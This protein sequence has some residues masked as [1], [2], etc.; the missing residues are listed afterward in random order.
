ML[1][2]RGSKNFRNSDESK[3]VN[4]VTGKVEMRN[5]IPG[6]QNQKTIKSARDDALGNPKRESLPQITEKQSNITS[7]YRDSK[8]QSVPR[9]K[10]TPGENKTGT[11]NDRILSETTFDSQIYMSN[12]EK[13]HLQALNNRNLQSNMS[14]KNTQAS[15]KDQN[16]QSKLSNIQNNIDFASQ[17]NDQAESISK[18]QQI[19]LSN[20]LVKEDHNKT[21]TQTRKDNTS[22]NGLKDIPEDQDKKVYTESINPFQT[23]KKNCPYTEKN[24]SPDSFVR[25]SMNEDNGIPVYDRISHVSHRSSHISYISHRESI[26]ENSC[27]KLSSN[28]RREEEKLFKQKSSKQSLKQSIHKDQAASKDSTNSQIQEQQPPSTPKKNLNVQAKEFKEANVAKSNSNKPDNATGNNTK[29]GHSK[30]TGK[31]PGRSQNIEINIEKIL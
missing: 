12:D 3:N 19:K 21:N 18:S 27:T 2:N 17:N 1:S 6:I 4:A 7:S 26:V 31:E 28:G 13:E 20:N 22:S 25:I 8:L 30:K 29:P 5:Q 23:D 24:R 9:F 11:P 15:S 14:I 16:Y 10:K